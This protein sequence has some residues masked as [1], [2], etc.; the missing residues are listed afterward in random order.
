MVRRV[1][2]DPNPVLLVHGDLNVVGVRPLVSVPQQH[3][4]AVDD[5]GH[6]QLHNDAL[7]K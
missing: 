6:A 7:D 3:V 4:D 5:A 1:V 2:H